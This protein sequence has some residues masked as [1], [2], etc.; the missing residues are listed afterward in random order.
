MATMLQQQKPQRAERQHPSQRRCC[1]QHVVKLRLGLGKCRQT[2]M[3]PAHL[4]MGMLL[5]LS[6]QRCCCRRQKRMQ[7]Q[8]PPRWPGGQS[9]AAPHHAAV[10]RLG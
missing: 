7:S 4:Q 5:L 2:S 3:K 10:H 1:R 6:L 8:Q 9:P